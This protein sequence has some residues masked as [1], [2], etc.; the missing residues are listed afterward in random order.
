MH[1][2]AHAGF[3]HQGRI[4]C[5]LNVSRALGDAQFKQDAFRPA[6]EQQVSPEPD[7]RE[8]VINTTSDFL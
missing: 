1:T 3:V 5:C 2:L 8:A 4:N 6:S 7:I